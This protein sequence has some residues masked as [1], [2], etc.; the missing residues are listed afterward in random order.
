MTAPSRD[1]QDALAALER[2]LRHGVITEEQAVKAARLI[3]GDPGLAFPPPPAPPEPP[4]EPAPADNASTP[5]SE[6]P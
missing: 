4:A 3:T 1:G 2:L 5:G 6:A